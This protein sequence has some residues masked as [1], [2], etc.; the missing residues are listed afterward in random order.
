MEAYHHK[1]RGEA[2]EQDLRVLVRLPK[3]AGG[4]TNSGMDDAI[5]AEVKKKWGANLYV[6]PRS[7]PMAGACF[8]MAAVASTCG[9]GSGG[10][11]AGPR[12][13]EQLQVVQNS[14]PSGF[15]L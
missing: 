5:G 6:V 10:A 2:C 14:E 12:R 1:K 3:G 9:V 13:R 7:I 8:A 4:R 15:K 11:L